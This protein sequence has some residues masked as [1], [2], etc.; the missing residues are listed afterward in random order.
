MKTRADKL[1]EKSL[2]WCDIDSAERAIKAEKAIHRQVIIDKNINI[3]VTVDSTT[4][5]NTISIPKFR[6]RIGVNLPYPNLESLYE[7][8]V[9]NGIFTLG[10]T[11]I[12]KYIDK[13]YFVYS[14]MSVTFDGITSDVPNYQITPL[15]QERLI[16]C[17]A[18]GDIT[19]DA[20]EQS[21]HYGYN[22]EDTMIREII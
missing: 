8:L 5:N 16:K 15:G 19:L 3:D 10:C 11:P 1:Y 14:P 18:Y 22:T 12:K 4:K 17:L 9:V 6:Q 2:D 21:S 20:C 13:G 7:Y